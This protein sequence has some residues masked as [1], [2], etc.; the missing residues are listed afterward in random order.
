MKRLL[1]IIAAALL[2][3]TG[4]GGRTGTGEVTG[5]YHKPACVSFMSTGKT[6][7]PITHPACYGVTLDTRDG[8]LRSFCINKEA[9]D[10]VQPGMEMTIE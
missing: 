10:L 5:K 7:V 9:W 3:L 8:E 4:C 1:P 6:T 2:F